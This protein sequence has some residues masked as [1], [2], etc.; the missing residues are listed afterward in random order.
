MAQVGEIGLHRRCVPAP[1]TSIRITDAAGI[2]FIFARRY[3][4]TA[5]SKGRFN[6]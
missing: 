1:A 6:G 2:M 4:I 5:V 3:L